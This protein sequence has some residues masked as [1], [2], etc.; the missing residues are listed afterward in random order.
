M[1]ELN[2]KKPLKK[3]LIKAVNIEESLKDG[4]KEEKLSKTR[5]KILNRPMRFSQLHQEVMEEIKITNCLMCS[6]PFRALSNINKV[7]QS[8]KQTDRWKGY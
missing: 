4:K 5:N 6:K 8:C 1:T 3:S 2:K 7:C